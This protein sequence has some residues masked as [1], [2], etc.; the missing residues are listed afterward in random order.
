MPNDLV[1]FGGTITATPDV[2]DSSTPWLVIN[3]VHFVLDTGS[4]PVGVFTPI[5][6]NNYVV[7]GPDTGNGEVNPYT[8][9]FDTSQGTGIGSYQINSFQSVGDE[10]TG[11]LVISYSEFDDSPND[12]LFDPVNDA[13][14][15]GAVLTLSAPVTVIVGPA[16]TDLSAA[17]EASTYV[18]SLL[19]LLCVGLYRARFRVARGVGGR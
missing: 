18:L 19:G 14:A 17:P 13:L 6:T 4:Y 3:N 12:P 10:A 11:N 2:Y 8:Q 5:L 1:G 7:I 9:H 15:G 16:S